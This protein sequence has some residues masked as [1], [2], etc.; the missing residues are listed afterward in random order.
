MKY[1]EVVPISRHDASLAFSSG[2]PHDIAHALIR[3][4]YHD[5]DWRWAQELCIEYAKHPDS[6]VAGLA[7]TCF[8]HLAR[9]HGKLD[10]ERVLPILEEL[11]QDEKIGGRVDD[12]LGDIRMYMPGTRI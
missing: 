9:I 7:V 8:G 5:P 4:V 11:K 10:L 2:S 3:V 12:A 6:D 1:H